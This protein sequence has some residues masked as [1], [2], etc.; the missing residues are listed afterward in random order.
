MKQYTK[1]SIAS[2]I[3]ASAPAPK[4]EFTD[5]QIEKIKT[6]GGT[7]LAV[8]GIAG[9]ATVAMVA[10]NALRALELFYKRKRKGRILYKTK[11]KKL[12]QTLHYLKRRGEISFKRA[13]ND[14][15]IMLTDKGEKHLGR[16]NFENIKIRPPKIWDGKF[17]LVAVDIPVKYKIGADSFRE[18]IKE[19]G[20]FALQKSLW[21]YPFDPR[22]EIEFVARMFGLSEYVT[23]MKIEHLDK[24]DETVIRE[25]FKEKGLMK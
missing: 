3:K 9:L 10:P 8:L 2:L 6:V 16:I 4:I 11:V 19:L 25:Y 14:Y 12:T 18:K 20:L 24:N 7:T 21:F 1:L 23:E 5:E 15:E 17:W 13:G 22:G